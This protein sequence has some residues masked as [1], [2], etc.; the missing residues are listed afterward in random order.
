MVIGGVEIARDGVHVIVVPAE[1]RE[2]LPMP[3]LANEGPPIPYAPRISPMDV[4]RVATQ[5]I[6]RVEQFSPRRLNLA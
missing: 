3:N 6:D 4:I 2:S 1:L 5:A